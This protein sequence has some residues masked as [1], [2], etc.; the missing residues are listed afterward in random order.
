MFHDD[1]SVTEQLNILLYNKAKLYKNL[2]HVIPN[3]FWN[4][5]ISILDEQKCNQFIKEQDIYCDF[6]IPITQFGIFLHNSAYDY[7]IFKL[8]NK[9]YNNVYDLDEHTKEQICYTID[10]STIALKALVDFVE[11]SNSTSTPTANLY[12]NTNIENVKICM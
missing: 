6:Q 3:D 9:I 10:N 2:F 4:Y 7:Y 12:S 1:Y 8:K 11:K 5:F